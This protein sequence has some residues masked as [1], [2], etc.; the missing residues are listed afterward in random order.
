MI[1]KLNLYNEYIIFDTKTMVS[2]IVH[3]NIYVNFGVDS[4][5]KYLIV[6]ICNIILLMSC[7]N[8]LS[9]K[10]IQLLDTIVLGSMVLL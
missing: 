9:V 7:V 8:Y 2:I 3:L 1:L 5:H 10:K 6:D 4:V